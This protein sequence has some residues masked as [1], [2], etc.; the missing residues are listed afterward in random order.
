MSRNASRI[1]FIYYLSITLILQ[2]EDLLAITQIL[3]QR[4]RRTLVK[5]RATLEREHAVGE[6]EH[7]IEVVFDD[8]DRHVNAQRVEC[9]EELEHDRGRK[10]L[11]RLVQQ[12]ELD[13]A[14]ERARDGNHLLFAAGEI[15]GRDVHALLQLREK[16]KNVVFAPDDAGRAIGRTIARLLQITVLRKFQS[17]LFKLHDSEPI[18]HDRLRRLPFD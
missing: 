11:E 16:S 4:L 1:H 7:E 3:Q 18:P 13:V 5:D 14:R 8:Q 12:K 10:P 6:R 9:F 15:I 17:V 2:P